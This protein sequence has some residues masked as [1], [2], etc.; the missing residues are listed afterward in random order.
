M[1]RAG[2]CL[3]LFAFLAAP[4]FAQTRDQPVPANMVLVEGGSFYMGYA[5]GNNLD[6]AA[7]YR[8]NSDRSPRPVGTKKP[9]RLGLYNMTGNVSEWCWDWYKFGYSGGNQTNPAG[10]PRGRTASFA[11]AIVSALLIREHGD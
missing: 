8:G 6:E 2:I 3:F 9:N 5:G 10:R 7:W 4:L 1:P 11:T